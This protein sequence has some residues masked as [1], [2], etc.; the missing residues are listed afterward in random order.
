MRFIEDAELLLRPVPSLKT[1][2]DNE[3]PNEPLQ[4]PTV[5]PAFDSDQ[6]LF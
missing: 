3:P 2:V 5:L 1:T 4:E 6:V